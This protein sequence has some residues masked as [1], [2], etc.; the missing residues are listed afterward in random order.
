MTYGTEAVVPIEISEPSFQTKQFNSDLND[1]DLSLNLNIL[2]I[3][4][5]KAQIQMVANKKAV[6]QSYNIRVRV[7]R[8]Q[9]GDLV[10]KKVMQKQGVFS[11]N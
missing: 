10:F 7:R 1:Q 6:A 3:T 8:F 11:P 9:E 5:D 2:E 4:W